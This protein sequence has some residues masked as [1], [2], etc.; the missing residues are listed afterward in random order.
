MRKTPPPRSV[1]VTLPAPTAARAA[2]AV[3]SC[4]AVVE[5]VKLPTEAP[6][7]LSV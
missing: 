2:I 7:K 5:A 6:P 1:T 3:W 4:A